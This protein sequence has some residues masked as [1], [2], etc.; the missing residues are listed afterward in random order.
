MVKTTL[1]LPSSDWS[2]LLVESLQVKLN[3]SI[4]HDNFSNWTIAKSKLNLV[5]LN[6][7]KPMGQTFCIN[8]L[9][10]KKVKS[11]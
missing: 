5:Y 6:K 1:S 9:H 3:P 2:Y 8:S 7:N 11:I 10:C 4:L